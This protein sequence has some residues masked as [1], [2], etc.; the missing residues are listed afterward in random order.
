MLTVAPTPIVKQ[1]T[2]LSSVTRGIAVTPWRFLIYGMPGIGKSTFASELPDPVF[3]C[4]GTDKNGVDELDVSRFP[5]PIENYDELREAIRRLTDEEHGWKS[6][7]I[8]LVEGIEPMIFAEVVRLDGKATNIE[9]VGGGFSKGYSAALDPWRVILKDLERLQEKRGT[10]IGLVS[11]AVRREFRDP[12]RPNYDRWEPNIHKKA[13]GLLVGWCKEVLFAQEEIGTVK[14]DG[15]KGKDKAIITGQR[16][17][18]TRYSPAY[19]AKNRH[20]L[21]DPLPLHLGAFS[22]AMRANSVAPPAEIR[23]S[24]AARLTELADPAVTAKVEPLVAAH[25]E[26]AVELS[27]IENRLNVTLMQRQKGL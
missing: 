3:F 14:L 1:R 2:P 25:S 19:D 11:H 6:L 10:A 12:E 24:I 18:R 9:D 27:K 23:A 15:A 4:L 26:N 5:D 13:S 8:D 20:G 22:D 21:P 16:V 7:V 17:I